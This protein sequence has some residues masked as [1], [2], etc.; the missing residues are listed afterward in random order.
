M[1]AD[2]PGRIVA[3]EWDS[4]KQLNC[5]SASLARGNGRIQGKRIHGRASL[6]ISAEKDA[7]SR[8]GRRLESPVRRNSRRPARAIIGRNISSSFDLALNL[9]QLGGGGGGTVAA[10]RASIGGGQPLKLCFYCNN[11]RRCT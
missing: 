8:E 6:A 7:S 1:C 9:A 5:R 3:G 11:S 10:V 2:L 4:R